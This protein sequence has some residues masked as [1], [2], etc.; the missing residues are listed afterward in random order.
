MFFSLLETCNHVAAILFKIDFSWQQGLV[1]NACTSRPCTWNRYGSKKVHIEPQ[2]VSEMGWKKP[3]Y[4]KVGKL[5]QINPAE[6]VNFDVVKKASPSIQILMQELF[7]SFPK[8][9]VFEHLQLKS[10]C[11]PSC[12]AN[13]ES[14]VEIAT[15]S[16]LPKTLVEQAGVN[17]TVETFISSLKIQTVQGIC[18][19]ELAT[20]GQSENTIW[21]E[22]RVGRISS[23]TAHQVFT[24]V[25]TLQGTS[26]RSRDVSSLLKTI[27]G[28][29]GPSPH[30]PAIKY[31][32][33][34]EPRAR[35]EYQKALRKAGH[36]DVNVKECG[37]FVLTGKAYISAS[38]DGVVQCSCCGRGVVEIKCPLKSAHCHPADASLV[39]M[40]VQNMKDSQPQLTL[41]KTHQ[42]YTQ[43]QTQLAV[44]NKEWCDFFVYSHHGYI[45]DRVVRNRVF[46]Q[47]VEAAVDFFFGTYVAPALMAKAS[48]CSDSTSVTDNPT[49]VK[50]KLPSPDNSVT[51][52]TSSV[53]GT[54]PSTSYVATST[55]RKVTKCFQPNAKKI[56]GPIYMCK[57]CNKECLNELDIAEASQNSV[58]C[59]HCQLWFH[60]GC[61]NFD[62]AF[63][64]DFICNDCS[65]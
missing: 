20:R 51:P 36:K 53:Q 3:H 4:R 17:E 32:R 46:W 2:L 39:Y 62:V 28:E 49:N 50:N 15:S 10:S 8:A 22:Q 1:N 58:C 6:K 5:A 48:A 13:V 23:S 11:E 40:Q 64:G 30:I 27:L 12:D 24:K 7:V 26:S 61:V 9:A 45:I 29:S 38:P 59:E 21:Q 31:G 37:M 52:K 54:L 19:L 14:T 16:L 47:Q 65:K 41:S 34:L 42:Y 56:K 43:I 25:K 55:K 35:E 57:I 33:V 63:T 18:E 44:T 60:F